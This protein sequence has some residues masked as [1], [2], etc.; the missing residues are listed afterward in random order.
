MAHCHI[1]TSNKSKGWDHRTQSTGIRNMTC[2][3]THLTMRNYKGMDNRSQA[4]KVG[5]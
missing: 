2:V 3:I 5:T 1:I 4:M